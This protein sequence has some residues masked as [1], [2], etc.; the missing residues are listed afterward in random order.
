MTFNTNKK[1]LC[2]LLFGI[3]ITI[4]GVAQGTIKKIDKAG[5]K[6]V[7]KQ[8]NVQLIDVRTMEEYEAHHI[9]EAVNFYIIYRKTF[10]DQIKDLDKEKPVYVYCKI[11]GRSKR[12][13]KLLKEKGFLKIYDY[14]GGYNDWVSE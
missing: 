14:S 10:V 12:A 7:I 6:E 2:L 5:L 8:E 13:A 3:F 4:N 1:R 11:G 9:G